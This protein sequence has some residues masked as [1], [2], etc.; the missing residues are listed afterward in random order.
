MAK[1]KVSFQGF[2]YIEAENGDEAEELFNNEEF[3][4]MECAITQV[5]EVD[6]FAV[7]V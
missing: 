4:Y 6:E 1:Y 7:M 2:A 5:L 3:A